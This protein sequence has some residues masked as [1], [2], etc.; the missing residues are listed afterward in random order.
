MTTRTS[1]TIGRVAR[2]DRLSALQDA[3]KWL[4]IAAMVL[5]H[6]GRV[7]APEVEGLRVVG[8]IAWPLF[9]LLVGVNLG[10]RGVPAVRYLPRLAV[11]AVPAQIAFALHGWRDL[12]ILVTLALGVVLWGVLRGEL[13]WPWALLLV[14]APAVEYG[15]AGVLLVP[16]CAALSVRGGLWWGSAALTLTLLS[17]GSFYWAAQTYLQLVAVGVSVWAAFALLGQRRSWHAS[18]PDLLGYVPRVPRWFS[19]AF[20]PAHLLLLAAL[21]AVAPAVPA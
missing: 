7:L 2:L 6:V 12:N 10:A 19:Y 21:S 4:A 13:R 3:A 9:A 18:I 17:Q 5:D 11:W 14:L 1:A 20:Y 8:R 15:P 16:V